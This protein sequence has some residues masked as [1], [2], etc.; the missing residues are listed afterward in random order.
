M[1]LSLKKSGAP[2][3]PVF[4][5]TLPVA[6]P[7]ACTCA[8][9]PSTPRMGSAAC[10]AATS[11]RA[12]MIVWSCTSLSVVMRL[13]LRPEPSTSTAP[14]VSRP[15]FRQTSAA[16]GIPAS[17]SVLPAATASRQIIVWAPRL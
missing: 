4:A 10:H 16:F 6:G 8:S 14:V 17:Q 11:G 1:N 13:P 2:S 9:E 7:P 5:K 3:D 15:A 12:F